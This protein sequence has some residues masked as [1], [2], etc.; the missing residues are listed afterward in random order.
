MTTLVGDGSQLLL[1]ATDRAAIQQTQLQ[2]REFSGSTH[3]V[4]MDASGKMQSL[5]RE[6]SEI[7]MQTLRA[8]RETGS[9]SITGL[10][11]EFTS[12]TA[13]DLLGISR[14][15]LLKLARKGEIE[16]F[17]VGSHTRFTREA[18]MNFKRRR[19]AQKSELLKDITELE[20]ELE[21]LA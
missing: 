11:E 20:D 3:L 8:L 2:Q 7:L 5:P 1:D 6:V 4:V 13:A 18:I 10:P 15:T 14:P 21:N 16:S 19:E 12:N 9:V 17:K